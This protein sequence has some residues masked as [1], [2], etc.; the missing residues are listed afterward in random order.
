VPDNNEEIKSW[1]LPFVEDAV[2]K[3]VSTNAMNKKPGWKYEPPEPE[4]EIV[5][6]TAADIEDIR[7]AAYQE[8]LD[9]GLAEGTEK[10]HAE[11]LE[12]GHTEGL[13]TGHAEGLEQ[14]L[15]AA[16]QDV[17]EQLDV[18]RQLSTQFTDP[19]ARLDDQVEREVVQLAISLARAVVRTEIATNPEVIKSAFRA[20]L[21]ALPVQEKSYQV[22]LNPADLSV[23]KQ[24][25]SEDDMQH[26]QWSLHESPQLSQGGCEIV[27]EN[28]SVDV[29]LERQLRDVIDTF[30]FEQGLPSG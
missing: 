9:Q 7:Q 6:P 16:T 10:G 19:L 11:G 26:Q 25:L 8:G 5:L 12:Q 15:A 27:S 20:G 22:Y 2:S 4:V 14:G 1:D 17:Q 3:P 28:N 21:K 13:E 24:Q 30:L 29:T 18:W 23:L